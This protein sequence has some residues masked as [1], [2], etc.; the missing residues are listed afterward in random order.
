MIKGKG[1]SEPKFSETGSVG[2]KD[3]RGAFPGCANPVAPL[4]IELLAPLGVLIHVGD[5]DPVLHWKELNS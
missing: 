4:F 2:G 5:N 3:W 1:S